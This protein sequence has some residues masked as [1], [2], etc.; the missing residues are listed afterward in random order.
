V[1]KR[2]LPDADPGALIAHRWRRSFCFKGE[3]GL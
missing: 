2:G 1:K 3:T